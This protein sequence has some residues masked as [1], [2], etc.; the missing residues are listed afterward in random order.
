M[1]GM[2]PGGVGLTQGLPG[3]PS[4]PYQ[5]Q[6][7]HWLESM[8]PTLRFLLPAQVPVPAHLPL[9]GT[10]ASDQMSYHDH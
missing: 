4:P 2:P 8:L 1:A 10:P 3:M 5:L 7:S 9:V 6:A